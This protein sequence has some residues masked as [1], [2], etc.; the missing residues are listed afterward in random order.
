[1]TFPG[2]T[3]WLSEEFPHLTPYLL[4]SS[5]L[6]LMQSGAVTMAIRNG[7]YGNQERSL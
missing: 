7:H 2:L 6:S 1:M 4:I 5:G 3:E